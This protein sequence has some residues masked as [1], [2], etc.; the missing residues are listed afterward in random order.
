MSVSARFL[1][2][3]WHFH[4]HHLHVEGVQWFG[5]GT[6]G[7]CCDCPISILLF[8]TMTDLIAWHL[9]ELVDLQLQRY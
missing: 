6:F 1:C 2:T 7:K 5:F 4:A 3:A 9:T 8:A